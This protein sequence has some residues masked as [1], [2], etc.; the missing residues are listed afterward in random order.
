M[1]ILVFNASLSL[2]ERTLKSLKYKN[3]YNFDY[4]GFDK[5]KVINLDDKKVDMFTNEKIRMKDR[6]QLF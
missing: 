5:L 1:K 3:E 2:Y 6:L 4:E